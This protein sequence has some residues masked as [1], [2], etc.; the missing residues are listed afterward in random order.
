MTDRCTNL[1]I[2][3]D[4]DIMLHKGKIKPTTVHISSIPCV[5]TWDESSREAAEYWAV[6]EHVNEEWNYDWMS[7]KSW[8]SSPVDNHR[9]LH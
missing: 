1:L 9:E 2:D 5:W 3:A 6:V 7:I 4:V 8:S